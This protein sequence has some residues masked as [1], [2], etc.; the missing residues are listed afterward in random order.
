MET[1]S[2][3][4]ETKTNALRNAIRREG[5]KFTCAVLI[6]FALLSGTIAFAQQQEATA[7][8]GEVF[9]EYSYLRFNPTIPQVRNR[10]FNGGGGGFT[11]FL[12]KYFGIK[13][14]FM[15]YAST[16]FTKVVT[17]PIVTTRGTIPIGVFSSQGNMFTYLFGPV[18]RL[19]PTSKATPFGEVL[20]GGSNT[21][22]YT[23]LIRSINAGGGTI[24]A[25]GTQHP[26]TMAVGGGLDLN[27]SRH[28]AV[29]PVEIDYLLTR[30][31]NPLTG[32]NNQNN[33]RYVG[34][35][36]YKF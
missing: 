1:V 6:G 23:G 31:S 12:G 9:V 29:R 13:G 21:N 20:F 8:K 34:G 3:Q 36:A 27:V 16:T 15:G 25:S 7:S 26:F 30:Y 22:A 5:M 4:R 35:I 11:F 24:T 10:S 33:F 17:S 32:T 14:E 19:F 2:R 28:F 18:I